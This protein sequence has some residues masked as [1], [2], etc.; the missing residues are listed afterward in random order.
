MTY[1]SQA[2]FAITIICVSVIAKANEWQEINYVDDFTDEQNKAARWEDDRHIIQISLNEYILQGK[3]AAGYRMYLSRKGI[4]S[5]EPRTPVELRVDK[6]ELREFEAVDFPG[7]ENLFIWSPG[8][9][10]FTLLD[11][12]EPRCNELMQG[13][14]E[15]EVLKGRYY[16]SST[17]RATFSVPLAGLS[18]ILGRLFQLPCAE[19]VQ[20]RPLT[21]KEQADELS[22]QKVL[23]CP[24][25]ELGCRMDVINCGR[26]NK[27]D[28][29]AR[30]AC[31][32]AL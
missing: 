6:R 22:T 12:E 30:V 17:D 23:A 16:I 10:T 13:L 24:S 31:L 28:Q 26:N 5:F 7:L 18:P 27:D 4:G 15:G 8:T 2:I 21:L 9:L 32:N 11:A 29:E 20:A 1:L 3:Q 25:G 14:T 19:G